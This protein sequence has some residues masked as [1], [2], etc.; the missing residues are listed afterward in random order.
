M[1]MLTL[2]LI[3][4]LALS[5]MLSA[6][7]AQST[8]SYQKLADACKVCKII[9]RTVTR[10]SETT[11]SGDRAQLTV[12]LYKEI[13]GIKLKGK[14]DEEQKREIYFA[15]NGSLELLDDDFDSSTPIAL[16]DV[17]AQAPKNFD[18]VFWRFPVKAQKQLFDRMK[19]AKDDKIRPKAA[20]PT[21]KEVDPQS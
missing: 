20:L 9:D 10:H 19:A 5:V 15:I 11:S 7:A 14:S 18:F 6:A 17:R 2:G 21:V 16:L 4:N 3:A 12:A 8:P 1:K 13:E